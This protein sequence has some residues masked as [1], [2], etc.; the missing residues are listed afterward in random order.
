MRYV[1]FYPYPA[2]LSIKKFTFPHFAESVPIT[3]FA[4]I[5]N[6]AWKAAF[7]VKQFCHIRRPYNERSPFGPNGV[8]QKSRKSLKS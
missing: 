6:A 1:L 2:I 7:P 3:P 8:A 4:M 5:L